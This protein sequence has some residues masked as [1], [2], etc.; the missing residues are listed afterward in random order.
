MRVFENTGNYKELDKLVDKYG[1]LDKNTQAVLD[2][3]DDVLGKYLQYRKAGLSTKD[4]VAVKEAIKDAQWELD[5]S[6][7]T[8]SVVKL[9]G[10]TKTTLNE[11]Q[12]E[13]LIKADGIELSKTMT[14]LRSILKPYGFKDRDIAMWMYMADYDNHGNSNGTF[15]Q[16]EVVK[17]LERTKGLTDTQREEIYQKMKEAFRNESVI[18]RWYDSSYTYERDYFNRKGWVAGRNAS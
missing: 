5:L 6:A 16:V 9:L 14:E 12:I 8:G 18:N 4:Y 1:K 3:K 13:A 10:L 15:S 7:N 11:R 2:A 17:A